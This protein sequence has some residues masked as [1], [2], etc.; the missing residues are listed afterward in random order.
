MEETLMR[1][2]FTWLMPA[3][4]WGIVF[5]RAPAAFATR[6]GR[7]LW[8]MFAAVAVGVTVRL[9]AVD[10]A[11]ASLTGVRDVTLLVKHLAGVMAA[12]FLLEYVRAVRGR[13]EQA[14]ALRARLVFTGTAA[15]TLTL[16]FFLVLPHDHDGAFGID[17]HYGDPGVELYLGVFNTALAV[18]STRAAVLFWSNRSRVPRGALRAGV[19]CLAMASVIGVTYTLYRVYFVLSSGDATRLDADGKPVP[20]TDSVCELLPA[21]MIVLFVLGVSIPPVRAVAGYL[22]DQVALWRLHPLWSDVT[23]AVPQVVLGTAGGRLR[24]LL[25]VGD[26]SVELVHRAFAIRDAVLILR[27]DTPAGDGAVAPES[28]EDL[29]RVEAGWLR[30]AL[31]NRACGLPAPAPPQILADTGGR[32]PREEIAWMLAV[33]AAYRSID[34]TPADDRPR[35]HPNAGE[36]PAVVG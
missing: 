4:A 15:V 1:P 30:V 21:V 26:R 19:T 14:A 8:G 17:A 11:L 31:R 2:L 6:A 28:D 13:P 12:H 5:W 29:V 16:L 23:A 10:T 25:A 33:A 20:L 27:E 9:A 18:A 7:S 36:A 3:F 35:P 34:A 32:T 22:R 24:G